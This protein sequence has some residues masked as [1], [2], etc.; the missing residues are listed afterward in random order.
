MASHSNRLPTLYL[1]PTEADLNV[2]RLVSNTTPWSLRVVRPLMPLAMAT[3]RIPNALGN[4]YP[5]NSSCKAV[6]SGCGP[7]PSNRE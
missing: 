2:T 6:K 5:F 1:A 7:A 4:P 3:R